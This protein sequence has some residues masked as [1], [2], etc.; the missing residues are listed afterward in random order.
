MI[1]F[2]SWWYRSPVRGSMNTVSR[3]PF[4]VSWHLSCSLYY[5][6]FYINYLNC[7]GNN[8]DLSYLARG[9]CSAY[10]ELYIWWNIWCWFKYSFNLW[11]YC[12]QL[13]WRCYRRLQ[14]NCFCIWPNWLRKI[15]YHAGMS[16]LQQLV[17]SE[18]GVSPGSSGVTHKGYS[19]TTRTYS[20][21]VSTYFRIYFGC[22]KY[23]IS[24]PCIIFGNL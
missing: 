13:G 16:Y 7:H 20:K 2:R 23:K 21:I 3:T 10:E 17:A 1:S 22:R 9:W 19:I 18:S 6:I 14:W 24:C 12:I 5:I 8:L 11:W 4:S 15:L